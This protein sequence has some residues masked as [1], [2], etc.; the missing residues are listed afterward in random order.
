M[1]FLGNEFDGLLRFDD[2]AQIQE[3]IA[4]GTTVIVD[5]YV[6]SGIVYSA[7]KVNPSLTLEWARK[8]DEGLPRPDACLFLSISPEEA[9]KR[10]GYGDERYEKKEMQDRVRQLFSQL[11]TTS[12]DRDNFVE[13]DGGRDAATVETDVRQVVQQIFDDVDASKK[14]LGVFEAW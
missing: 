3:D 12:P 6:Y 10:G 8:P 9:A 2:S 14:P 5:R 1:S 4:A 13:I 7:A 11:R